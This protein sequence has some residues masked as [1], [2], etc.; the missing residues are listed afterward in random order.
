[1]N[2]LLFTAVV[3]ATLTACGG[4]DEASTSSGASALNGTW[5][6]TSLR[7]SWTFNSSG[8]GQLRTK[9]FDNVSC[10][11]TDIDFTVNGS[12]TSITY[13]GT[14]YRQV[15]SPSRSDDYNSGTVKR[16]PFSTSYT[17][18]GNSVSIGNGTYARGSTA[19]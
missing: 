13:Y 1:M 3:C 14:N 6:S 16:G 9:S 15:S 4:E 10:Q 7:T 2:R 8:K 17:V 12:S 11:I 5:Y 19:C 18:S